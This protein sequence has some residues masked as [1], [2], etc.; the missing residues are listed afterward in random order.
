MPVSLIARYSLSALCFAAAV[1]ALWLLVRRLAEQRD[2]TQR[3]ALA[4]ALIAYL[5]ALVQVT[6]LR[7]G[8]VRPRWLMGGLRPIP[9]KTLLVTAGEGLWMFVYHT[10]G[11]LMWFAPLGFL[12]PAL[13]PRWDARRCLAAGAA[14][15]AGIEAAQ[16]LLGTGI[17]DV[18]DVL[19]NAL[20]ALAGHG[21]WRLWTHLQRQRA[22]HS[23]PL[24]RRDS[25]L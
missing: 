23:G 5:A 6:A 16:F 3:D 24:Q 7:V 1:A 20:G 11:N 9:L 18:D 15:S 21:A 14:L 17:C 13:S 8:L 4:L 10:L 2:F 19:L 22:A 12:L 25:M